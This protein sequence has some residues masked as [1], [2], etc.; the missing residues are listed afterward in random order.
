MAKK[1]GIDVHGVLDRFPALLDLMD[2]LMLAGHEVHIMTGA[3]TPLAKQQLTA[4]KCYQGLHYSHLF[5]IT[6]QLLADGRD[7]SWRDINNPVFSDEPWDRAK[8]D[9]CA[10]VGIDM[11]ID[12]SPVYGKYF[13]EGSNVYLQVGGR[14]ERA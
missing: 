2:A 4:L 14:K 6:S 11:L 3:E 12:D 9:Y 1:F 8:A 5:S 13:P 10:K 7:V